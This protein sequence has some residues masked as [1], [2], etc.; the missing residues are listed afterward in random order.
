MKSVADELRLRTAEAVLRMPVAERIALALS[1]GDQDL[2][3][4][5]GA[6]GLERTEALKRL[7]AQRA[8]GRIV[9]SAAADPAP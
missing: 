5:M 7:R 8:R 6:N 2:E 9:Y 4:Y 3:L 1:L